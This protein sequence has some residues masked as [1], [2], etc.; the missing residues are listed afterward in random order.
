LDR[1]A[2]SDGEKGFKMLTP[3]LLC[4]VQVGRVQYG[5]IA[6][7]D[8]LRLG[9]AGD[10]AEDGN[11]EVAGISGVAAGQNPDHQSS[12]ENSTCAQC[13][14]TF[15]LQSSLTKRQNKLE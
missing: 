5:R 14:K 11:L 4:R 7:S 13:Y 10:A 2:T 8:V 3:D 6:D 15:F 9:C 1:R 12:A